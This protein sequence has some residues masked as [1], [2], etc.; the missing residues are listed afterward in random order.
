[1]VSR[2][3]EKSP[4]KPSSIQCWTGGHSA[5]I[6]EYASADLA[7]RRADQVDAEGMKAAACGHFELEIA[8]DWSKYSAVQLNALLNRALRNVAYASCGAKPSS[9]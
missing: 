8:G 2:S 3:T 6:G 9:P 4:V 7:Q 5:C 1:V